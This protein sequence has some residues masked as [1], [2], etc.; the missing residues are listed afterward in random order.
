M[1]ALSDLDFVLEWRDGHCH[2]QDCEG[3]VVEV[4]L[5]NGCPM[6]EEVQGDQLLQWLEAF[7]THQRRKLA[8]VRT[9]LTDA[10]QV[11]KNALNLELALTLRLREQFPQ[12]PDEI[13]A[14]IVPHLERTQTS[15]FDF[16]SQLPWNR[17]KRRRLMQAKHIIIHC[18]S[19]PDQS[20][21]DKHCGDARTE[22]LCIDTTCSTP[23]NLHN[24]NIYGFLLMLCASGRVR[25]IIGG[26]PCRTISALRYQGDDGPG[27]LRDDEHPYG[28]PTLSP[29]DMELTLVVGDT[30]LM[31]RFWSLMILAEEVRTFESPPTQFVMEQP[32][33]PAR[34]RA[35][36]DVEEHK[37][38][39][40]YRTLEWGQFAKAFGLRQ[41]HCDQHPMGH[42]KRKPTTLGTNDAALAQLQGL[43]GAPSDES[44]AAARYRSLTMQQR[45]H[46]SKSW[47][48]WAPGLKAAIAESINR[49]IK[50]VDWAMSPW[51]QVQRQDQPSEASPSESRQSEPASVRSQEDK[52]S[53]LR[54][55]NDPEAVVQ[56]S[57]PFSVRSQGDQ[58]SSL[59]PLND[60]VE[61][62][63]TTQPFS[64]PSSVDQHS[65]LQ[66][67]NDP[68]TH[69]PSSVG[70]LQDRHDSSPSL[71]D[72]VV[73]TNGHF[74][75][76]SRVGQPDL[77]QSQNDPDRMIEHFSVPTQEPDSERQRLRANG[78]SSASSESPLHQGQLPQSMRALGSVALEQWRRHFLNDHLP[79]RRDCAQCVRAQ[80]RNRPHR[81]IQHPDA[82]TLSVDLSGRLSPGDDQQMK[83][84]RYLLVGCFT[85]PVTR[86]GKSLVPIPGQPDPEEQDQPLP[87]LDVDL[88][89]DAPL[90]DADDAIFPEEELEA[91]QEGEDT[92]DSPATK[93]AKSMNQTWLR[94]VEQA[95]DVTVRQLTF[96]Q[97]VK[98]RATKHLLPALARIYA[99]LRAL[100]PHLQAA[101]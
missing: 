65:S 74:S 11:D 30:V 95:Q 53:S 61:G 32:E 14:R 72:P 66:S 39:S 3:R 52:H 90:P 36:Q 20:Y 55:L 21:W 38:F 37:Y 91:I 100:G 97:P 69:G 44:D 7:Q 98:S 81:R 80:A 19:G 51:Q 96:V 57:E 71:T 64:V 8:I 87:G 73:D 84:C 54:P 88:D 50:N 60:P 79:A 85:Y 46:E 25:S 101:L 59:R 35:A 62:T 82:Y 48:C 40:V 67:L 94:L 12:L 24:K 43:R 99:R 17:R 49:H 27:V 23:A 75:V 13:M 86:S 93:R 83:G 26:P 4:T 68:E 77:M 31:F 56:T 41:V 18:F 2:L 10:E 22:V 33:D 15:N 34:Y 1:S 78:S 28:R 58:H 29:S 89:D 92:E 70:M 16:A 63:L 9:M 45:C 76:Q 5:Q 47:A 6:L 42:S